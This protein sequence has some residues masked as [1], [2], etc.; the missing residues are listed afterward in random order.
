MNRPRS[1]EVTHAG[2]IVALACVAVLYGCSDDP[3]VRT[4]LYL[5]AEYNG[6]TAPALYLS[7]PECDHRLDFFDLF[8][9]PG[10]ETTFTYL[11]VH[12]CSRGGTLSFTEA[13]MATGAWRAASGHITIDAPLFYFPH[14]ERPP[15]PSDFPL[16]SNCQY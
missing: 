10:G 6:V 2:V 16:P 1:H 8:I 3:P 13:F 11:V 14:Q 4:G 12:D 9:S 5:L 15:Q 7:T